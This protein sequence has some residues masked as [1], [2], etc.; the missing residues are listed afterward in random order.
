MDE[1]ELNFI[2]FGR[3]PKIFLRLQRRIGGDNADRPV[4][5]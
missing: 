2:A 1:N 3:S 5:M 4:R